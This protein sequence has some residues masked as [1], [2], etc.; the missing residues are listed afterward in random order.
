MSEVRG[1]ELETR[2]GDQ[3]Q[4]S[5][6]GS[7]NIQYVGF[8][9]PGAATSDSIWRI[10]KLTYDVNSNLTNVQYASGSPSYSQIW[11]NKAALTYI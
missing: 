10:L 5:Y 2:A 7:N 3:V 6:D 8:A 9:R 4:I 1:L 11:D